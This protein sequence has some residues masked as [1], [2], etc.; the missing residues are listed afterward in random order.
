MIPKDELKLIDS[1]IARIENKILIIEI[2]CD[3]QADKI[4][5]LTKRYI[6]VLQ[7]FASKYS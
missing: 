3:S 6:E 7:W 5:E 4:C 2:F 1:Q